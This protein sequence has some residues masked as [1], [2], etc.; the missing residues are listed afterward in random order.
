VH[1]DTFARVETYMVQAVNARYGTGPVEPGCPPGA[2]NRLIGVQKTS[3]TT[4]EGD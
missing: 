2:I 4:P 3:D 1:K